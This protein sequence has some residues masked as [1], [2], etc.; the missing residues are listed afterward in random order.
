MIP[1]TIA[2]VLDFDLPPT[3]EAGQPPEARGLARDAVRL[4][5]SYRSDD[6]LVHA[7][8]RDLPSFLLPGDLLVI[9]TS[10]TLPAALPVW[11]QAGVSMRLHLSNRH[12]D[13]RWVVELRK[14]AENGETMPYFNGEREMHF[15]LPA[16]GYLTLIDPL[17]GQA[18]GKTRLWLAAF[19]WP[20]PWRR[21]LQ[22]YGQPIRYNYVGQPWSIDYYQT[23]FAH[24]YGSAEM[25]SAGRGF[26]P[27]LISRLVAQGI[28][29]AP[30]TLHTGVASLEADEP[31]YPEWFEL[32]PA[33]AQL[34]NL[35]HQHGRRIIGVGTTAVRAVESAVNSSGL[36]EPARGWTDHL[37]TPATPPHIIN[38]L[39]TGLHEPRATHLAMLAALAD[40]RHLELAYTEAL[41]EKYLWHEFGDLHLL[42]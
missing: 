10:G 22:L 32:P 31:P 39:L 15:S 21:F 33:T 25:P 24:H 17:S 41:A 8:F 29:F 16:G 5:V 38:G 37:I 36:V 9:N 26:T 28:Q 2:P 4:L 35:A 1:T 34:L 42:I 3:L 11:S 30:V 23:V 7:E 20:L 19:H 12:A 6:R 13:D 27:R 18:A 40:A 14:L